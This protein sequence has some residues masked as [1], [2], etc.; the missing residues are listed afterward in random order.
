MIQET[1]GYQGL[2]K[3]GNIVFDLEN[4]LKMLPDKPGVYIMHSS[5]DTVIYVGK[6][7]ILK[8][9][10]RQYFGSGRNHPP[11]VRAMVSNIAYFEYII[12][13]TEL[14]ALVLECNL[15][16]KYRPHYNILLKDDKGYPYIKITMNED[17]PKITTTRICRDDGA[18]YFGP[19]TGN[20][21]VKNTIEIVQKIF[22]PPVCRR[23][24]PGD[25]GKGRPCLNY[26]IK[27]CFGPCT[28]NISQEEYKQVFYDICSFLSGNHGKIIKEL[29]E[30]M[31]RYAAEFE[32]ER[33]ADMRDKIQ[34]IRKLD[35]KQKIINTDKQTN[36]DIIAIQPQDNIAFTEVFFVRGGK[37][38]GRENYRMENADSDMSEV[39]TNFIMLFY[40]SAAFVPEE[41]IIEYPIND[42]ELIKNFLTEKRG[43]K[44]T[45][46]LPVKGDK[47]KLLAMV[48]EN[49][50]LAA[51]NYKIEK[52]KAEEKKSILPKLKNMLAL[53]K[54][55]VRIESYDI[56]NISGSSNVASMVVFTNAVPDRKNYRRFKI[57]S[58]EGADDYAAMREVIYRRMREALDEREK[59]NNGELTIGEAKFLPL[60][61][62]I[63][64]DGGKGHVSVIKELFEEIECDIPL[65]GMVKD[66]KHRTR[67]MV[68]AD[69]EEIEISMVG[70]VFAFVTRIQDEV[71]R[72]AITYHRQTHKK[73]TIKSELDDIKGI[74]E[75]R[76]GLLFEKF[77]SVENIK[78]AE[79]GE[80]ESAVGKQTADIIYNY[81]HGK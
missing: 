67:A 34:A 77:R 73:D 2:W 44:V 3:G 6:A 58:F 10:V 71:H 19:Y 78:N 76:R 41:I 66:D 35:E 42:G 65:Y 9:R 79:Y 11:K 23:K 24:F 62:C 81:F 70:N 17:Y 33:A 60:P 48:K 56:S 69:G 47:K 59:I 32:Y 39:M 14:E 31:K 64:L 52:I 36:S 27:N 57:S 40:S 18:K 5:D 1:L 16:K 55:P 80:L 54:M 63:F 4:E 21:T 26:Y 8:N 68:N 43:R 50:V 25:I 49:A 7:K 29:T 30:R 45:V 12:T 22:L 72:F 51:E 53:P 37:I 74:G 20:N 75:K 46:T 61:D 38:I 15:I 13:D 28:G